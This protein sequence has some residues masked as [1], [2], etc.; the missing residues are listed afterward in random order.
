MEVIS[1]LQSLVSIKKM[2][3]KSRTIGTVEVN[4]TTAIDNILTFTHYNRSHFFLF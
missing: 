3:Y 2:I 4:N 1:S